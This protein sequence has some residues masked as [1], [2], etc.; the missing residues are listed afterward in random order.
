MKQRIRISL[1]VLAMLAAVAVVA[2]GCGSSNSGNGNSA[3]AAAPAAS[4]ANGATSAI[5]TRKGEHGTYLVDGKGRTLYLFEA[6]KANMSNCDSGCQSIWP[7]FSAGSKPPAVSGGALAGKLGMTAGG[8][9]GSLVT[10]NGH[11]LY[12]YVGDKQ[13]GDT[14]GQGLDQFGAKW[15][16]LAP[17]GDKIDDD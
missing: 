13:P 9:G 4:N 7:A 12:Y 6:D 17:A 2:A 15:Y 14:N 3:T 16:V 11:P 1:G 5:A 10:Y 8:N